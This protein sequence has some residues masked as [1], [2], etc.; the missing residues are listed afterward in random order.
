MPFRKRRDYWSKVDG[1]VPRRDAALLT[2][3]SAWL[4]E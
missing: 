3:K 1:T 4:A 2:N